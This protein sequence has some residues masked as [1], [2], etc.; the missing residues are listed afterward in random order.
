ME[1]TDCDQIKMFL[2]NKKVFLAGATGLVGSSILQHLVEHYPATTIRASCY[3]DIEPFIHHERVEYVSGDLKSL[4]DCRKMARG[5][6]CAIMAAA[7]TGGAGFL[8]SSPW[9]HIKENLIMNTQMLEAFH[10]ENIRRIIFI[11]SATLY[12]DCEGSLR[13]D[14]LD[15]NKDPHPAYR[16]FGWVV[17][18]I[19]KLCGF[20]HE[21][22]GIEIVIARASNIF[23]PYAKF[24]PE[25]S[26][27]IPALIHKAVDKMDPFEVWGGPDVTRDVIYSADFA[28]AIVT[29]A[30]CDRIKYD[31]FNVGSGVK[32]TVGEIVQ[33]ALKYA[34]HRPSAITYVQDRPTT[35]KFRV[36]DCGKI[37][38][39]L[40]W[41]PQ[42]SIEEGVKK[43]T[44]WWIQNNGWWKR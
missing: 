4:G 43:T 14:D 12:Q 40:G 28:R 39:V 25:T 44:E 32:T 15:L 19:E 11:G 9:R 42:W 6:D 10:Q 27:F 36:L 22:S 2:H 1:G 16:G 23:G 37:R 31:V 17:R 20:L 30:D 5:C 7:Y 38:E 34:G 29:M 41:I 26:N 13:E 3:T 21:E 8:F 35:M 24:D 18:F 33:W